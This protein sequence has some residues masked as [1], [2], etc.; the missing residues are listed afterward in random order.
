MG[1]I[2]KIPNYLIPQ[3]YYVNKREVGLNINWQFIAIILIANTVGILALFFLMYFTI[4]RQARYWYQEY[5]RK[6]DE[7]L[8]YQARESI[9]E[10]E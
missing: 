10:G 1:G 8:L 5:K 2:K 6:S 3:I 4:D 9:K 7:L